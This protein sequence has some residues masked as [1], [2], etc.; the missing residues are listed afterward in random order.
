MGDVAKSR[1]SSKDG[2]GTAMWR[3]ADEAGR[4]AGFGR[5]ASGD[6]VIGA[7][8][9]QRC[10]SIRDKGPGIDIRRLRVLC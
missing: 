10:R 4:R 8:G 6:G 7:E 1:R 3:P 5:E 2:M 9:G